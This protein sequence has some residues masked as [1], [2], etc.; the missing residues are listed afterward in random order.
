[1]LCFA[2]EEQLLVIL[3][4][5]KIASQFDWIEYVFF[6]HAN[7]Y[8]A[9]FLPDYHL[10]FRLS[11]IARIGK[12]LLYPLY[13]LWFLAN[14]ATISK[15]FTPVSINVTEQQNNQIKN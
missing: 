3:F 5:W 13:Q 11:S 14:Q 2:T 1:M 9:N 6:I 8:W 10:L 12:S 7:P 15:F 4:P